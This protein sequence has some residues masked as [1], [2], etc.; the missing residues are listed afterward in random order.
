MSEDRIPYREGEPP[1]GPDY[2][3]VQIVDE[4]GN[5]EGLFWVKATDIKSPPIRHE[6]IDALLPVIRWQWRHLKQYAT[7]C[8]AFEDWERGFLQDTHPGSEVAVWTQGT[9][10]FLEFTHR[11]RSRDKA[12]VFKAVVDVLNGREALIR[13]A[14][15]VKQLKRS[16]AN[17]P[18]FLSDVGN[19]TKHGRLRTGPKHLR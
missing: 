3:R 12:V 8:R 9:Y 17:P 13:P 4:E 10:A 6:D 15:T 11:S 19:F 2:V 14:S 5:D 18:D 7:G 1:P 16:M